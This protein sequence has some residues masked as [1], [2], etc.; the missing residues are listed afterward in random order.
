[1][2]LPTPTFVQA[3]I[4]QRALIAVDRWEAGRLMRLATVATAP[5]TTV[6]IHGRDRITG[7]PRSVSLTVEELLTPPDHFVP[8]A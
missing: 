1:L 5:T 7:Q 2:T 4:R 3:I 6:E 8:P